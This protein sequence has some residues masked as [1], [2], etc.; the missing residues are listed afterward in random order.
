MSLLSPERVDIALF[1]N[2][3][4]LTR[5]SS[6]LRRRLLHKEIV[7]V[8]APAPEVPSLSMMTL[9]PVVTMELSAIRY[10][11]PSV[12]R[13]GLAASRS[14]PLRPPSEVPRMRDAMRWS[15]A[16]ESASYSRMRECERG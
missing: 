1:A 6:G 9:A 16:A 11:S 3:V 13:A 14:E 5:S 12:R 7:S 10:I 8:P 4:L 2:R 15:S